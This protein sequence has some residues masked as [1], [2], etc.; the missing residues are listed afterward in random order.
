MLREAWR[1]AG[2]E[3]APAV[4]DARF[5]RRAHVDLLGVTPSPESVEAFLAD[6]A[7]DRREKA[8]AA[9]LASPRYAQRWATYWERQLLGR[10]VRPQLVDRDVFRG[11]LADRFARNES[12]A[13]LVRD[14]VTATGRNRPDGDDRRRVEESERDRDRSGNVG[15]G[16]VNGAVN[17]LLKYQTAPADLAGATSRV[18]LGVQIQCAQCHDHK[19]EPWKTDDFR[20]LAACF[21]QTRLE[22]VDRE[23]NRRRVDLRDAD[24]VPRGN[25][26][27]AMAMADFASASPAALD[28]TDFSSSPN[29]R[30][31]LAAWLTSPT[32][33]WF[34][35]AIVN[36]MWALL[37]G[38]G[39]T[40]PIDDIRPSNPP[41]VPE[42]WAKLAEDFA[43]H[44]Y[45]LRRLIALVT[46]T[47]AYQR[48][49]A[50]SRSPDP[51]VAAREARLWARFR[52][53]PLGPDELVDS[54]VAA[55]GLDR[56]AERRAALDVEAIKG[57][58]REQ[59]VALFD[60]DE[61]A[62]GDDEFDGTVS[63]ALL[64]LN[65][66]LTAIG[67]ST[68]P[69][70]ALAQV[71]ASN[72]DDAA[73]VRAL[74]LR[75]LSRPPSADELS[76]ALT[77]VAI[78]STAPL[79]DAPNVDSPPSP[80]TRMTSPKQP[81]P[82]RKAGK[83]A[84]PLDRLARRAHPGVDRRAQAWEDLFWALLNSSEFSFNR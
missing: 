9:M 36:R 22:P 24:R 54:L 13:A 78:A 30:Q 60:V 67:A 61:E 12:W 52:P 75:T 2:V 28:G 72:T 42:L 83:G 84:D 46:A 44:G 21:V 41:V 11:W 39:F 19:T 4:D 1:S 31:A 58:L 70:G 49:S 15:A 45:D 20:R 55:T 43:A 7:P 40:D 81:G 50:P 35:R 6:R 17:W 38:K 59:F 34:A 26:K 76:S 63:Q 27:R 32:N 25:P 80:A 23:G 79:P 57:R 64:L 48:A 73:K 69:G 16:E 8:V 77:F 71:L 82:R 3:P 68:T 37:L 33:P 66:N 10:Q 14:L 56:V 5:F 74:Y 62:T 47:E 51:T 65:G 29:R 18:F 53:L